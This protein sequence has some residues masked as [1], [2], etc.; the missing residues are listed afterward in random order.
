M[1]KPRKP[2]TKRISQFNTWY[3]QD[4]E[5]YKRFA[6]GRSQSHRF[7]QEYLTELTEKIVTYIREK[8]YEDKPLT[9]AGFYL[10]LGI[11]K[12]DY[13]RMKNG[14]FDYRLYQYMEYHKIEPA[15]IRSDW[16]E[17]LGYIDY[18]I[19]ADGQIWVMNTYSEIIEKALLVMQEQVETRLLTAKS[20][21]AVS[22][23]IFIMKAK[24]GWSDK[25]D[26]T[27]NN[28]YQFSADTLPTY[29]EAKRSLLEY[30]GD[31]AALKPFKQLE[32]VTP[33]QQKET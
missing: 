1:A 22:A 13:F 30:A 7:T 18:W 32:G 21:A 11:Q 4:I 28:Y 20:N 14:E 23:N 16:Q 17:P 12:K 8:E 29:E 6:E 31:E 24:F 15:E 5:E 2:N 33:K 19:D 26:N 3:S 9:I 10:A 25:P 27:V